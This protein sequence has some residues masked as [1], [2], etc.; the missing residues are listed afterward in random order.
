MIARCDKCD[1]EHEKLGF[2]GSSHGVRWDPARAGLAR[3]RCPSCGGPVRARRKGETESVILT[4]KLSP[5]VD[6]RE[7]AG[8]PVRK[9]GRLAGDVRRQ[10]ASGRARHVK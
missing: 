8:V 3:W 1:A 6:L 4:G 7:H 10:L 9:T 2:G 5:G